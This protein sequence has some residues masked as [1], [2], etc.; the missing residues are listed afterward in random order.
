MPRLIL[1]AILALLSWPA[2]AETPCSVS[3]GCSIAGGRYMALAPPG[4]DGRE[5]L[6]V[7]V[8]FHGWRESAEYV[9]ADPPLKAFVE[10][11]RILLIAPHGEGNTWSYPGAPGKH[12]DEFAFAADLAKDVKARF[13]VDPRRVVAA[14][15]SQGA[16]MI[17]NIACRS[18]GL[19]TAY[20]ALAGGFWEPSPTLCTGE[21]VDLIHIHGLNDG[22]VPM[23]GR[24]LRG[25]LYR[26]ADIRRDWKVWLAE[27]GCAAEP[28]LVREVAGRSCRLWSACAR[29]RALA[30][31]THD[32]GHEIHESDLEALWTFVEERAASR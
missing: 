16:S 22:T 26:Q 13:P 3:P 6:P 17:W 30:F 1:L 18:P 8:F 12:R 23:G 27:D 21:G 2:S 29:P 15:F 32:L 10:A 25:G 5:A 7:L 20:G 28:S 19:F 31:C 11:R 4:W 24:M 14:G 9:V